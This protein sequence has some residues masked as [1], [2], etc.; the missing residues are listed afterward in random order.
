M[1]ATRIISLVDRFIKPLIWVTVAMLFWEISLRSDNSLVEG[2]WVF[3]WCERI[4]G[5]LFALEYLARWWEDYKNPHGNFDVG[6]NYPLSAMGV[7]DLLSF[8]PFLVGFFVPLGWLG[9]IRALRIIRLLKLFRYWRGLQIVA[10][11]FYKSWYFLKPLVFALIIVTLFASV[12]MYECE[13]VEQPD[14][15]GNIA[16]CYWFA[17]VSATT[18]GYGDMS[19]HTMIGKVCCATILFVPAI[20]IF[21]AVVGTIGNGFQITM[22]MEQDPTIDPI[23]EFK[24]I[25]HARHLTKS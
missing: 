25:W 9:W 13:H 20:L 18:V 19:P 17:L 12:I 10:L 11:G 8:L 1:I 3:L 24:K 6:H 23:D 4:I 22:Q 2:M 16:N 5:T 15:F 7:I 21:A 14:T